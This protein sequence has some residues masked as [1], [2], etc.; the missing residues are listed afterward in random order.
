MR[1]VRLGSGSWGEVLAIAAGTER[2]PVLDFL[3]SLD[4]SQQKAVGKMM[5]LLKE[6]V[7]SQGPPKHNRERCNFLGDGLFEFKVDQLRIVWFYD[8]HRKGVVVCTHGFAKKTKRIPARE[9]K[10]ARDLHEAYLE[11]DTKDCLTIEDLEERK[12]TS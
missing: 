7:P 6:T 10:R 5:G 3:M 11:A 2:V 1:V 12:V 9:I 4:P 8:H